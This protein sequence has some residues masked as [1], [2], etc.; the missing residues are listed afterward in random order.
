MPDARAVNA[1]APT[2]PTTVPA[3]VAPPL[4]GAGFAE[5][6]VADGDGVDGDGVSWPLHA[7][8]ITDTAAD[9]IER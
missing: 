3:I 1:D 6:L 8:A 5:G 4:A 9:R 7:T 2:P